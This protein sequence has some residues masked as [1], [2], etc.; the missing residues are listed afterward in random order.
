MLKKNL[1][2]LSYWI[3]KSIEN[4]T[5]SS[6][7]LI[8][9]AAHRHKFDNKLDKS[10]ASAHRIRA[11]IG[12]LVLQEVNVVKESS[13]VVGVTKHLCGEATGNCKA[14]LFSKFLYKQEG[15]LFKIRSN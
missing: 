11:D 13:A 6:V 10:E 12:D 3:S 8:E 1:G 7:L 4:R 9:R 2:Q 5:N 15:Y 14:T